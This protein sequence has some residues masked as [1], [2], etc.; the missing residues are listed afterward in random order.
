MELF[1]EYILHF[2]SGYP[3]FSVVVA[4]VGVLRLVVPLFTQAVKII[5]GATPGRADDEFAE[6]MFSSKMWNSMLALIEWLS[7]VETKK[8]K[9]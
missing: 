3:L 5:V 1:T 4:V 2:V 8:L 6:K 7:S 9:K